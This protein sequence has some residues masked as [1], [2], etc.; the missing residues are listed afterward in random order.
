MS[1]PPAQLVCLRAPPLAAPADDDASKAVIRAVCMILDAFHFP[2]PDDADAEAAA[3]AVAAA[4]GQE[5]RAA[6]EAGD[7]AAVA[8][9]EAGMVA[10]RRAA[11]AEGT[12][13]AEAADEGEEAEEGGDEAEA[14]EVGEAAAP[15]NA[16][17]AAPAGEVY[18]ML[19]KRVV[20][21]LQRI[22]VD[23]D[24]VR[25]PV[26][27]AGEAAQRPCPGPAPVGA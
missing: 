16:A 3:Q 18:R 11:A 22:M 21:E 27:L 1:V 12:G 2:L 13:A 6:A 17:S 9:A 26:A 4:A 20:P 25:A 14:E 23:R 8:A 7:E 10:A 19:A 5:L 15:A 24:T